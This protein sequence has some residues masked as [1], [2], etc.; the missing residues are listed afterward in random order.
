MPPRVPNRTA[1]PEPLRTTELEPGDDPQLTEVID[2]TKGN[3][4]L[5]LA[6][7]ESSL[8]E[9]YTAIDTVYSSDF[10][11]LINSGEIPPKMAAEHISKRD[12]IG[13]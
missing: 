7:K 13:R 10:T 9:K 1:S 11:E 8:D 3:I 12:F 6:N 4:G 5:I 2:L